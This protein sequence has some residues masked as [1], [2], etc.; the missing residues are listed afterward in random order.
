MVDADDDNDVS[1]SPDIVG[2]KK[3]ANHLEKRS[4]YGRPT[5][6]CGGMSRCAKVCQGVPW[7]G[8]VSCGIE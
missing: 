6:V 1:V 5:L 3:T 7:F 8:K 4:L 2:E